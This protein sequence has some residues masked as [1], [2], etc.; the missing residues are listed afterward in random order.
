MGT[1]ST[2]TKGVTAKAVKPTPASKSV[3]KPAPRAAAKAKVEVITRTTKP[4]DTAKPARTK[5]AAISHETVATRAYYIGQNR[6]ADDL[7]G[8]P[9]SDWLEAERQLRK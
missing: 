6:L 1:K 7:P 4:S 2:T 8:D 9:Q 5:S 3:V